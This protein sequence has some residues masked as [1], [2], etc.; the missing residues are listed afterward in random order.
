MGVVYPGTGGKSRMFL[1]RWDVSSDLNNLR[2]K[3]K[4]MSLETVFHSLGP[5]TAKEVSNC[6]GVI[7][8]LRKGSFTYYVIS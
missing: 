2:D 1:I 4:G 5:R 3:A 7:R 8:I 6:L